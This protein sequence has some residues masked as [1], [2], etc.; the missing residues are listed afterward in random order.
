MAQR[1]GCAV[2]IVLIGIMVGP[3]ICF[4]FLF[5]LLGVG[6]ELAPKF[7]SHRTALTL[8]IAGSVLFV[9]LCGVI[10]KAK[11][12]IFISDS[13]EAVGFALLTYCI[14]QLQTERPRDWIAWAGSALAAV[15]YTLYVSHAPLIAF[16]S[17]I[18]MPVWRPWPVDAAGLTKFGLVSG[19]VFALV[20]GLWWL[21][22]R[23]T[24]VVRRWMTRLYDSAVRRFQAADLSSTPSRSPE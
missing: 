10:L 13:I 21:F 8:S 9:A 18:V 17:N 1:L 20:L 4:Y 23:N 22:E 19:L 14:V 16:I 11:Q 24:P 3:R 6:I 12:H 15:S 7:F 5:W 2:A